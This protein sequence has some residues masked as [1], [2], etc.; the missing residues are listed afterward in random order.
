MS[1]ILPDI[2]TSIYH[3]INLS[4]L[5][6]YRYL[7]P[8]LTSENDYEMAENIAKESIIRSNTEK[9]H[10]VFIHGFP[11]NTKQALL[12]DQFLGG[13]NLAIYLEGPQEYQESIANML[14]YY[15]ERVI[16]H[17]NQGSLYKIA[18][19]K[20][21]EPEHLEKVKR[22]IIENIKIDL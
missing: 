4:F 15:E 20:S 11:Y 17:L 7:T 21:P 3:F 14:Q 6:F 8:D 2:S 5:P 9:Q 19:Y 12:L 10:G 22:E 1:P 16:I 13:V 18:N